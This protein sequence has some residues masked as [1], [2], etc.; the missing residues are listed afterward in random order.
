[1]FSLVNL[2]VLGWAT[3]SSP[4]FGGV[5]TPWLAAEVA[6]KFLRPREVLVDSKPLLELLEAVYRLRRADSC[7][8]LH[9]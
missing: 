9:I 2:K 6:E 1:M 7:C 3:Y 4:G 8:F 5:K